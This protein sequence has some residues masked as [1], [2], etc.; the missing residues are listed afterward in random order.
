MFLKKI[1]QRKESR[2]ILAGGLNTFIGLAMY[3]IL[4]YFLNTNYIF[5]LLLSQLICITL[6]FLTNKYFVYKTKGGAVY[7]YFKFIWFHGI[8]LGL[9]LLILPLLVE[10]AKFNPVIAQTGFAVAVIIT[11]YYWHNHIT[12]SNQT[13]KNRID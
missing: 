11:S 9:N 7:E 3:P 6:A 1:F 13:S 12:F 8:H 2:F 10:R 5:T 4:Y